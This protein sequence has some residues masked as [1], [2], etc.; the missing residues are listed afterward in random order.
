MSSPHDLDI[1]AGDLA[2]LV[3]STRHVL[4]AIAGDR[5]TEPYAEPGAR[6][7]FLA[8]LVDWLDDDDAQLI[9]DLAS[10]LA[11]RAYPATSKN[12]TAWLTGKPA[13]VGTALA[14]VASRAYWWPDQATSR[15]DYMRALQANDAGT[16]IPELRSAWPWYLAEEVTAEGSTEPAMQYRWVVRW[17]DE[18]DPEPVGES[19]TRFEAERRAEEYNDTHAARYSRAV[20]QRR[21]VLQDPWGDM[22]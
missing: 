5:D 8:Y 10:G 2:C 9:R 18:A 19:T 17:A 11:R 4:D 21:M 12:F 13:L 16:L 14:T 7:E 20:V 22:P 15:A 3:T 1:L 6:E